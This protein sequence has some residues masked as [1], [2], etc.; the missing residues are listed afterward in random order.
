[1]KTELSTMLTSLASVTQQ[2]LEDRKKFEDAT[3]L[4]VVAIRDDMRYIVDGATKTFNQQRAD[5]IQIV[6]KSEAENQQLKAELHK[7]HADAQQ[8]WQGHEEN[9]N[10]IVMAANQTCRAME[11][12]MTSLEGSSGGG[13]Y[14]G[15]DGFNKDYPP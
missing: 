2:Q 7:L 8:G 5:M 4:Q 9:L 13:G 14:S 15:G 10:N 11:A 6:Q 3:S 1:M 12:K